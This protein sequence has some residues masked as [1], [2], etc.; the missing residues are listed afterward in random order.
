MTEDA[1]DKRRQSDHQQTYV[2]QGWQFEKKISLQHLIT[3]GTLIVGGIL[4]FTALS[5][6]VAVNAT[7]ISQQ[8]AQMIIMKA[9]F[10]NILNELKFEM[11]EIRSEMRVNR[12]SNADRFNEPSYNPNRTRTEIPKI[13]PQQEE[14]DKQ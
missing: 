14:D 1:S 2:V 12:L 3:L 6:D 7:R 13:K 4:G 11:R 5:K 10:Q 9:D 8:E